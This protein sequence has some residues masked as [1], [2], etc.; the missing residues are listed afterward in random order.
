MTGFDFNGQAALVTGAARGLGFAIA[1][2]LHEAGAMVALNDRTADSVAAA[3]ERLGGGARLAA[4]PADLANPEGP[5]SAV[6]QAEAAFGRLDLLVNNA[7]VNIERPIETTDNAHWD[8]HLDVDLRAPFF[9]VQ[10][11]L[12]LL[13]ASKGNVV[14]IGSELGLH[15]VANNVAYIAAKHG[16][17]ALTRALATELAPAGIRVNAVCPGPMDTE[18]M[19]DCAAASGDPEG[20]VRSFES[21]HPLGRMADP[22]EVAAFVLAIA[23]PAASFVTG[24]S[25][26]ADGAST[27]G[28]L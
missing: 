23:S 25:L 7:A 18:L 27:A 8:L 17:L 21:Y 15:G 5:A 22:A 3:I 16:L 28:R 26:A 14:N 13:R 1:G 4:A 19:R 10:T 6:R 12:P 2:A 24:A 11:A 9:A 20:Y